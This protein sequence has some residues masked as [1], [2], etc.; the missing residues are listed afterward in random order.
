MLDRLDTAT[1]RQRA[2]VADASHEFRSPLASIQTQLEVA[3]A[4]RQKTDWA[5]VARRVIDENERLQRMV[6]DLLALASLDEQRTV[7]DRAVVDLDEVVLREI[8]PVRAR[9]KV[10]VDITGIEGGR[11][12]GDRKQLARL[13]R[14]VVENAERHAHDRLRVS[15]RQRNGTVELVVQDDGPGVLPADRERVFERFTRLDE[16]R[17]RGEGGAAGLGL[18]IARAVATAHGGTVV[19]G[20]SD[21]GARV[22]ATIPTDGA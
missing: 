13:V 2:F 11:V 1:K 17:S 18:A 16:A 3:L 22:V 4:R 14:N 19:I 21:A 8:E 15:L 10:S 12:L 5:V 7:R 9:G 6:D 20:D